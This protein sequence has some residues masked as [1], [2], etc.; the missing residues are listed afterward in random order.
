MIQ[1]RV[2]LLLCSLGWAMTAPG[3]TF[4][5]QSISFEGAPQYGQAD[6]LRMSGLAPGKQLTA[7]DI[8]A[9][10]QRMDATGL[11]AGIRYGT[12]N[13]VLRFELEPM[14]GAKV[15]RARYGNFVMFKP[16]ELTAEVRQRLPLFDG[17]VPVTGGMQKDI[18]QALS[19]V[20]K[21]HG[22]DATVTSIGATDGV[23]YSIQTPPVLVGKVNVEGV[24]LGSNANLETIRKRVEGSE[25]SEEYSGKALAEN[26]VDAYRDLGYVDIVVD[27]VTHGAPSVEPNRIVVDLVGSART[28]PRYTVAKLGLPAGVPGVPQGEIEGAMQL[29]VGDL[30]REYCC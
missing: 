19:A 14:A 5:P 3:Q 13:G 25:Y 27:Q 26:L 15:R 6:L 24:N 16:E 9:A 20:L 4:T 30:P 2:L 18:E 11:F 10:M 22:I 21:A 7:A 23:D 8:D 1:A 17:T 12:A 28:G 29:K